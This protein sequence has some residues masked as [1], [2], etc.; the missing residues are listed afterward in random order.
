MRVLFIGNSHTF[1]NDMPN[2]FA[3]ICRRNGVD[4]QVTMLA[5]GGVGWHYHVK[6]VAVKSLKCHLWRIRHSNLIETHL[7]GQFASLHMRADLASACPGRAMLAAAS[8]LD[9]VCH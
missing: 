8:R 7:I 1:F 2:T 3:E 5:H 6:H 4:M 9:A